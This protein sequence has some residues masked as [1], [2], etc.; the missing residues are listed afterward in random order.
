MTCT[1]AAT[2]DRCYGMD[3]A[4]ASRTL[5]D[6]VNTQAPVVDG[7]P[8]VSTCHSATL[9]VHRLTVLLGV[10]PAV[11][12][13]GTRLVID[14]GMT[15][16]SLVDGV[17]QGVP[18]DLGVQSGIGYGSKDSATTRWSSASTALRHGRTTSARRTT[19]IVVVVGDYILGA[20]TGV[21]VA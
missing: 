18:V 5:V 6:L 19:T 1:V 4:S 8:V 3:T 20:R 16:R 10:S 14:L 12:K 13:T 11:T 21:H 7:S 17:I 2:N 15:T 9:L